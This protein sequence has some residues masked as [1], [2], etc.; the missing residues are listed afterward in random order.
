MHK[1]FIVLITDG[2]KSNASGRN[3]REINYK[4]NEENIN[5]VGICYSNKDENLKY[6]KRLCES[7]REGVMF[8]INTKRN[9]DTYF[10]DLSEEKPGIE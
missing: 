9:I 5:L 6:I 2:F 1:K 3:E 10:Y 7:T 8:D 4:M